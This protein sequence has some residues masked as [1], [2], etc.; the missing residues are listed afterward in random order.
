MRDAARQ[1][2][3]E[4]SS[5]ENKSARHVVGLALAPLHRNGKTSNDRATDRP[6]LRSPDIGM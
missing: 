1:N 6:Q 4:K 2:N 3:D 5:Q